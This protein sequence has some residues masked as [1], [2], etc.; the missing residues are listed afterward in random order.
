[1]NAY[2]SFRVIGGSFCVIRNSNMYILPLLISFISKNLVN[3]TK[4]IEIYYFLYY[5]TE[6][7]RDDMATIKEIAQKAGVSSATVSRVLNRDEK[8]VVSPEVRS[9]ILKIADE[10]QYSTPKMRRAQKKIV[11]GVADW[12]IVRLNNPNMRQIQT[13]FGAGELCQKL[14]MT[15]QRIAYGEEQSLDGI[16]AFGS[17][18]EQ[19]MNFLRNQSDTILFI[20]SN[21]GNYE[22]DQIIMDYEQGLKDMVRYL[23]EKKEYRSIGYIG[24]IYQDNMV[25]IGTRR[26]E[27][28]RE[29]FRQWNCYEDKYFKVGELT[30]ESGYQLTK[31]L[32]DTKD[33][34]EVLILG[35]D[36]I[37][38]GALEAV[39]EQNYR[40]PKDIAVIIYQDIRLQDNKYPNYTSIC[41]LPEIVWTTAVKLL[42]ERIQDGR[43]DAM[44]V[45]LPPKLNIGE[46]A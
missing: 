5:N 10:L 39:K 32:L 38:E 25:K 33:V 23:L 31:E 37:A 24:G 13:E 35:N 2:K 15:L 7:R 17:F 19:E 9:Q 27:A 20:N 11:I 45:Y 36:E 29:I 41:M 43:K 1:M 6:E 46:S 44:K 8:I 4:I 22:F 42:A 16:I 26:L 18:S 14:N 12:H 21:Q 28:F 30:K 3:F 40:I 34:P